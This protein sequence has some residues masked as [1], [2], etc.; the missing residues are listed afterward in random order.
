MINSLTS[1]LK[2]DRDEYW[3]STS[4]FE[5]ISESLVDQLSNIE[6]SIGKY[7]VKA[8][9]A[10][11]SNN[12]GVDEHNQILNKRI[13]EH[14]KASCTSTEKLWAVRSMKLIYSKIGE[15]WLVLLPQLVPVIAELLED[16]DE[17]VERE[18][19]TGLVKVVENV[20]GEP[21]DR[22]LD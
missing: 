22:Y 7:L 13:V 21:F 15:S 8:I 2:F 3:K 14:M 16:D 1:S 19:R 4:R 11:A 12:S 5:L 9:G 20:L 6:N 18:V 17:E 10:L